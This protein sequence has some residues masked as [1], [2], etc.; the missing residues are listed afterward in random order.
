[1]AYDLEEQEQLANLKAVWKQYGNIA[2]WVLIAGLGSYAGWSYWNSF[3]QSKSSE[4][5]VLFEELNKAVAGKD[6]KQV[7]RVIS[8]LK[9][10]FPSSH[11]VE[12][13]VL[14]AAKSAYDSGDIKHAKELL[15]SIVGTTKNEEY[16]ALAKIRLSGILLDEKSF[17]DAAKLIN[18]DFPE[19]F[20]ADQ[21]DRR[22]DILVAQGKVEEARKAYQTALEKMKDKSAGK[23]LVQIKLDA[24]GGTTDKS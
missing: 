2:T 3:Q 14:I 16:R 4:A 18:S 11:Y 19:E 21:A 24:I 23:P 20:L 6:D 15:N 22:G 17:D 10:R 5:S 7:Q 12:M 1:M 9:E 13:S 8:D